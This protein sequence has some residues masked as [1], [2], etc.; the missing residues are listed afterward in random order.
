MEK[1]EDGM[2]ESDDEE[3][4]KFEVR[5]MEWGHLPNFIEELCA[6]IR[7]ERITRVQNKLNELRRRLKAAK[8]RSQSSSQSLLTPTTSEAITDEFDKLSEERLVSCF[9]LVSFV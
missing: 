8:K 6:K 2:V 5:E 9:D 4:C 1:E 3:K 7:D